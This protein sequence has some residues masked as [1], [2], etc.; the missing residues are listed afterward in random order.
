M[1]DVPPPALAALLAPAR[2]P[3]GARKDAL[4]LIAK[5]AGGGLVRDLVFLPPN[6][7]IDR[8][9]RVPIA[10]TQDGDIATIEAEVDGYIPAYKNLPHRIRLR[11]ETGFLSVAYFRGSKEMFERMWPVGQKRL[12]SGTVTFY[13]GM[14]QMLHPDH[15]V[16]PDRGEAPPPVEPVYPLTQGLAGRTLARTILGALDT[17]PEAPE[18]LEPSTVKA[19]DWPDFRTALEHIHRPT[20]PEDVAPESAFRTR[21]AYDE[22]FARQC[23][24]R[25]RRQ[26]RRKEPGRAVTGDGDLA[27]KIIASLPF[28]PTGAQQRSVNEIYADMAEPAPML[29]LLQ[30]DVGSGKTLV[31]AL[32]MARAAEAGLQSA[33]MA[34]TDLLARQHGVTLQPLLEAAGISMAVLTGR[35]KPKDRRAIMEKLASGEVAVVVGTHALFQEDVNFKDLGLI[36]IDEQHRFGVSDRMRM[37][38]KGF[39]PHV[40]VMSA[41]PIPRTLALSIHGDMDISILDEK[42]P[43]RQPIRTVA[44]PS[45]RAHEIMDAIREATARGERAYWVCPLIEESE[46]V[47]LAAVEDRYEEL[48][49]LFGK[50]VEIVHGRISPTAREAAME[51]FR[52]GESTVMVATT[53]IE[54]GV[55]VPEA[56]IMVIEHAERFGLAQLHQLRGRV[57]RGDKR[58]S[59]ILL[60]KPPIGPAAK[61]RLDTLRQN[62]DG[63]AIAEVDFK[64]RG[65]GDVLGTQQSG[66]PPFRLVSPEAHADMLG[67]ADKEARLAVERDPDLKTPRG[68]AVRLVLNIFGYADAAELARSG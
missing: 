32:A 31:A 24:L 7:A 40:L 6:S 59:C 37:V 35:D 55:N 60:W 45:T 54:V 12:V 19:H 23:A 2:L 27:D 13:E 26:H 48:K 46:A 47:D 57:G 61:E 15:V 29:R 49:A 5:V 16:D 56:T 17:V 14:R 63:F 50:G 18:W 20:S 21:L 68:Q 22:L 30:G 42:P 64:M 33:M 36:V 53:V 66:L 39:A 4:G 8:R 52:S 25:L 9:L 38:A 44:M 58:G 3:K 43:G 41:T 67:A 62:D 34:P 10:E 11:D 28:A 51:R 65:A 1:N